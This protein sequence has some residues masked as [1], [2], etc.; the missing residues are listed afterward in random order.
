MA[1]K[2]MKFCTILVNSYLRNAKVYALDTHLPQD[3]VYYYPECS[4]LD[5][6]QAVALWIMTYYT[7][8]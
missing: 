2:E 3:H 1:D 8:N 7:H 4:S 6:L 5:H